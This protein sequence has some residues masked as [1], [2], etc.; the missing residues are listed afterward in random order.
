MS[1][2]ASPVRRRH[3][4][5]IGGFDPRGAA[6]HYATYQREA[7]R[8]ASFEGQTVHISARK[9]TSDGT[10]LW[11]VTSS[12]RDLPDDSACMTDYEFLA[13]DAIVRRHWPRGPVRLITDLLH[14]YYQYGRT[15]APRAGYRL[16][17]RPVFLMFLLPALFLLVTLTGSGLL[18]AVA[19]WMTLAL[20][21]GKVLAGVT[22]AAVATALMAAAWALERR[23]ETGWISRILAFT[24]RVARGRAPEM[25][26]WIDNMAALVARRMNQG[27]TDE[28]LL[29]GHSVG[30][31]LC[32]SV[33]ARALRLHSQYLA[34][35]GATSPTAD[36]SLPQGRQPVL[37]LLSLGH[38]IPLLGLLPSA[39]EFRRELV[40][41]AN[42]T[43]VAWLDFSSPG[44]WGSF[45]LINPVTACAPQPFTGLWPL[46]RSPRFHT[47]FT[48]EEYAPLQR[49]KRRL[50][51][52]YLQ[53]G[54]R[55]G[56]YSYF[57][58]TGGSMTLTGRYAPTVST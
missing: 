48:P 25:D 9:R 10:S 11:Q 41:L 2:Q 30:S 6:P 12:G 21:A 46:M 17:P 33:A 24:D 51:M 50:H 58:I 3:V 32:V 34:G 52:Q 36:A 47:L 15:S 8:A 35:V 22:G 57:A 7:G 38:C 43:D 42:R 56:D 1:T 18:G 20:G 37:S 44:D 40:E 28:V 27:D 13:W 45:A 49:N 26:Q 5:F 54:T 29:V 53:A 23:L 39:Q 19:V 4:F 14:A 55:Q 31:I 16:V